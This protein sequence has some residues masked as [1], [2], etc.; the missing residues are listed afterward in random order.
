MFCRLSFLFVATLAL[1]LG[2]KQKSRHNTLN[3]LNPVSS[4]VPAASTGVG[5]GTN[6]S[7]RVSS[8]GDASGGLDTMELD[9]GLPSFDVDASDAVVQVET[10][11]APPF[12]SKGACPQFEEGLNILSTGDGERLFQLYLPANSSNPSLL[13]LWHDAGTTAQIFAGEV[14]AA[15]LANQLEAAVVLPNGR[16]SLS[17]WGIANSVHADEDILFFDDMLACLDEKLNID[18][19]RVYSSGV[20]AGAFWTGVLVMNRSQHLAAAAL[21]NGGFIHYD[22]P[23]RV[24]PVLIA[25]GEQG[26]FD[27][28]GQALDVRAWGRAFSAALRDDGHEVVECVYG[29]ILQLATEYES[30][31][32][33][34][35]FEIQWAGGLKGGALPSYLPSYCQLR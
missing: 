12:Y 27:S 24:M 16:P 25:W 6:S 31:A 21:F 28:F 4:G 14:G 34:F 10:P 32:L 29:G 35:L 17:P 33:P 19:Q 26:V 13:F 1:C 15:D 20:G 5:Q 22:S 3:T 11:P 30:W 18:R 9:A 7:V 23:I 8:V 2:C